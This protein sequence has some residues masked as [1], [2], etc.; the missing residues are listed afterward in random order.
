MTNGNSKY[1]TASTNENI[2]YSWN[3]WISELSFVV[4]SGMLANNITIL[5]NTAFRYL[6][7]IAYNSE[8]SSTD[9]SSRRDS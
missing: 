1:Y 2:I 4:I 5:N 3:I 6:M 9:C 7:H 8:I